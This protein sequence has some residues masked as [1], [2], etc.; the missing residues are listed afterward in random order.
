MALPY[1]IIPD[2]IQVQVDAETE[3]ITRIETTVLA[4]RPIERKH[5]LNLHI[6]VILLLKLSQIEKNSHRRGLNLM[7]P[8]NNIPVR[9]AQGKLGSIGKEQNF[10]SLLPLFL[11]LT[12]L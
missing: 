1:F 10:Q 9:Q 2:R 6:L 11:R 12:P 4:N 3:T 7:S 5:I 8:E